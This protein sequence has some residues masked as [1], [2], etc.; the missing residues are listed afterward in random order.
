MADDTYHNTRFQPDPRRR[1]LWRTLVDCVFQKNIP[2]DAA[3]LELGAGYG[4]FINS[5][6]AQRRIAVDCWAGMISHLDPGV[7]GL[8]TSV[9]QLEAV[10]DNAMDYV[11]ASNCFEHLT[12]QELLDCLAQLRR[13]MKPGAR[14]TIVQPNF[15]YCFREYFD[16]YTHV[17]VYTDRGLCDLLAANGFQIEQCEPRFLPLTIKSSAPVHPLL[18][19]LYLASPVKPFGKQMLISATR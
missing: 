5:V 18:I 3:V 1:V 7:E 15:K 13:K 19:R 12:R 8:V 14:L 11:F 9:T 10:P 2:P 6:K 4:D 17:S 16:D